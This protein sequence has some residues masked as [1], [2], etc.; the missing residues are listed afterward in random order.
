MTTYR[1]AR[2]DGSQQVFDVSE[3]RI[4]E[5]LG[6]D[7]LAHGDFERALRNLL[8][9]GIRGDSQDERMAGLRDLLEHLREQRRR[10][11][12]RHNLDPLMRD[13]KERLKDVIEAERA[14]IDR[15]LQGARQQLAE[16]DDGAEDLQ[17][18]MQ[19]LEQRA[20]RNRETLDGLPEST[21]GAIRELSE[22]DFLDPEARQKFQ[23]LLDMLRQRMLDSFVQKLR[24][25]MQGLTREQMEDRK[26]MMR[27]LNQMLR[28]RASGGEPDFDAF[29][30]Q[31]GQYFE[32]NRPGTL[33]ELIE[34]LLDQT[35]AMQSLMESLPAET[36]AEL[37]SLMEASMDADM[38]R[39]LAELAAQL[40]QLSPSDD[41]S[42]ELRFLGGESLTLDQAMELM[43]QFE[44]LDELER[45]VRLALRSGNI[46]DIDL[47]SVEDVLGEEARRQLEQLQQIVQRLQEAGYLKSGER[48]ELTPSSPSED[49]LAVLAGQR[50]WIA[51]TN[52]AG[53]PGRPQIA[54]RIAPCSL[55]R[56]SS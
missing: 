47:D 53:C 23:E 14:G 46:D 15:R 4:L 35:A 43:E 20:R 2:W 52:F 40:Q 18:A 44:E 30:R 22:Y 50:Q 12:E 48:L 55:P 13:I 21:A 38:M 26:N 19:V 33:D 28:D 45:Q 32:P 49:Y 5:A 29:M 39:E 25:E 31:H 1:Y 56:Q 10:K 24:Q 11:L 7:V 8:Q 51:T 37:E 34:R 17:H 27:G 3:D 42:S 16:A 6:D 54:L 36:R 41:I 9:R